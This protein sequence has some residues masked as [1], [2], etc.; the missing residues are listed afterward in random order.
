MNGWM[1]LNLREA[2]MQ[3]LEQEMDACLI[4]V[5]YV[6][7]YAKVRKKMRFYLCFC[8]VVLEKKEGLEQKPC[9][10]EDSPVLFCHSFPSCFTTFSSVKELQSCWYDFFFSLSCH[11]S[12]G[13][14]RGRKQGV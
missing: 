2:K 14:G 1:L 12:F 7:F 13:D 8:P 4:T 5:S 3:G 9:R 6:L 11:Q 10:H